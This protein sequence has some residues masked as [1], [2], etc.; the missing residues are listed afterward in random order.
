MRPLLKACVVPFVLGGCEITAGNQGTER[1]GTE[2]AG[3]EGGAIVVGSAVD[4][5][6][7]KL[8]RKAVLRQSA[9]TDRAER[10]RAFLERPGPELAQTGWATETTLDQGATPRVVR[11]YFGLDDEGTLTGQLQL[12]GTVGPA[13]HRPDRVLV[14]RDLFVDAAHRKIEGWAGPDGE[15]TFW[16]AWTPDRVSLAGR[17]Q[18]RKPGMSLGANRDLKLLRIGAPAWCD[19]PCLGRV[20]D[21]S[22][23]HCVEV[24][25]ERS[26]LTCTSASHCVN[27]AACEQAPE[28]WYC[29]PA[30]SAEPPGV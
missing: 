2:R 25:P 7:G 19:G 10:E 5:A 23:S 29:A 3:T 22:T 1:S 26:D 20:C 11:L 30:E 15:F 28:G 12:S 4:P 8:L 21:A 24:D 27:G 13:R 17:V 16:L 6:D 18:V 9:A 14:L